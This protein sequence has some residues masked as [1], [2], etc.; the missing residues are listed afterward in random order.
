MEPG[1]CYWTRVETVWDA[2]SIYEEPEIFLRQFGSAPVIAR[3]LFA[4]H[5]CQ[6]EIN[7]GGHH[8][9]FSNSTG[10]LAPEAIAAFRTIG[11]PDV[12][13]IVER[14]V[15]KLGS[16]YPRVRAAR[17]RQ[18]ELLVGSG[19]K[20]HQVFSEFDDQ[21]FEIWGNG[22]TWNRLA[23]SYAVADA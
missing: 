16:P 23:D 8:Q 17:Q 4:G 13:M 22:D 20:P 6:S 14:A 11:L 7:N 1:D 18:L 21:F 12:A 3:D 19:R 10:I 5:W 9:F 2:I 15:S